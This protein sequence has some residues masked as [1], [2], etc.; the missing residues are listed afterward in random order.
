MI[1]NP[2]SDIKSLR[3]EMHQMKFDLNLELDT[4]KSRLAEIESML[5]TQ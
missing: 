1:K 3:E 4:V 2:T 5:K